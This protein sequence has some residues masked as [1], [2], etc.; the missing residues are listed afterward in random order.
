MLGTKN[1]AT[2]YYVAWYFRRS[3]TADLPHGL[4]F[5]NWKTERAV[6]EADAQAVAVVEH[7]KPDATPENA[8]L[9]IAWSTLRCTA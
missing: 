6:N 1:D 9:S 5:M 7:I 2:P 4:T 8:I 3:S